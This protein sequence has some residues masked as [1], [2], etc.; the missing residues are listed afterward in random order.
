MTR[1]RGVVFPVLL[2]TW[3]GASFPFS[4]LASHSLPPA[5]WLCSQHPLEIRFLSLPRGYCH[6]FPPPRPLLLT[7]FVLLALPPDFSPHPSFP[8]RL[9]LSGSFLLLEGLLFCLPLNAVSSGSRQSACRFLSQLSKL[10]VGG[11]IP[12]RVFVHSSYCE[13]MAHT[14]HCV[15]TTLVSSLSSSRPSRALAGHCGALLPGLEALFQKELYRELPKVLFVL[16]STLFL[17][18]RGTLMTS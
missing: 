15:H 18:A 4:R 10:S 12:S 16:W 13:S 8:S 9:S 11:F 5:P 1:S 3:S 6:S 2:T 7:A 17:G 14:S